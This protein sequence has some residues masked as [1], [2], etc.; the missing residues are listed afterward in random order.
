MSEIALSLVDYSLHVGGTEVLSDVNLDIAATSLSLVAGPRWSGKSMLLRSFLG[1]NEEVIPGVSY[2]GK[3]LLFGKDASLMDTKDLRRRVA[4]T[5][6][7]FLG[8]IRQFSILEF[9]RLTK[10]RNFTFTEFSDEELDMFEKMG[11]SE[12]LRED[13]R[14]GIDSLSSFQRLVLLILS[15]V[16]R[17]PEVIIFDNVLDHLDDEL[18]A[19]LKDIL[20][21]R[22]ATHTIV[23]SSR[24]YTRLLEI[25]DLMI[26]LRNGRIQYTGSPFDFV[27]Q[28]GA[29]VR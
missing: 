18:V 17:K 26:L 24:S 8:A 7:S 10:G 5:D 29:L 27:L 25:S 16:F 22:K 6:S 15:V 11:A 19:T 3:A 1:L 9:F 12:L 20:A 28:D 2:S 23:V 13:P 21:A 14:I 4:Y